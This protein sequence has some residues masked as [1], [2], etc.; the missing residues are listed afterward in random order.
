MPTNTRKHLHHKW[1][2]T[3]CLLCTANYILPNTYCLPTTSNGRPRY[4]RPS[5][6][7]RAYPVLTCVLRV[8]SASALPARPPPALYMRLKNTRPATPSTRNEA[9]LK[10]VSQPCQGRQSA[11]SSQS[12][13]HVKVVSQPCQGSQPATSRL[14]ASHVK[15]VSQPR[16]G[17]QPPTNRARVG[18]SR[19]QREGR[20]RGGGTLSVCVC[21]GGGGDNGTY[22]RQGILPH[23]ALDCTCS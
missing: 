13:S 15:S 17:S 5:L 23:G 1:P 21:V 9:T 2:T 10:V 22:I 20:W 12:A 8:N 7:T 18:D 4:C 14:S 6:P 3:Y 19:G 16:Q 11:T